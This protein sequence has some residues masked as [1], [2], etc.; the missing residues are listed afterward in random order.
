MQ[1]Y[2]ERYE[3]M[4]NWKECGVCG[5]EDCC[6]DLVCDM[7]QR[8]LLL[9]KNAQVDLVDKLIKFEVNS[10]YVLQL[11]L[12]LKDGCLKDRDFICR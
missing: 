7:D 8:G 1:A 11:E 3:T 12:A 5:K 9:L 2:A 10:G 6:V 4:T